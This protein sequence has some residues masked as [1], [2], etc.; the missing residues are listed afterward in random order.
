[1]TPKSP[2]GTIL[3]LHTSEDQSPPRLSE[4]LE[5]IVPILNQLESRLDQESKKS[6]RFEVELQ[7]SQKAYE[8]MVNE[9]EERFIS[10]KEEQRK[11][12]EEFKNKLYNY[13]TN[14]SKLSDQVVQLEDELKLV[15]SKKQSNEERFRKQIELIEGEYQTHITCFE[16]QEIK[17][18]EYEIKT[19]EHQKNE[20]KLYGHV[21]K[22]EDELQNSI[23][24][25]QIKEHQ[26]R[27]QILEME[28][29]LRDSES[30][31]KNLQNK[32]HSFLAREKEFDKVLQEKIQ[33]QI[34]IKELEN[35]IKE[36][37]NQ[38]KSELIKLEKTLKETLE[39]EH[40]QRL[41]SEKEKFKADCERNRAEF[42]YILNRESEKNTA[43]GKALKN[44]L[45]RHELEFERN[46][47]IERERATLEKQILKQEY[48]NHKLELEQKFILE[49]EKILL[50]NQKLID[51]QENSKIEFENFVS[52]EKEKND[53]LLEEID[54]LKSKLQ[55]AQ[56][57]TETFKK[58]LEESSA[59]ADV[60]AKELVKTQKNKP[61]E[62]HLEHLSPK[63]ILES[64]EDALL[65]HETALNRLS[66]NDIERRDIQSKI[67]ELLIQR[68]ELRAL[69]LLSSL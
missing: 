19:K 20:E 29:R 34:F 66:P 6:R 35:K 22:I 43:E 44:E 33:D 55:K 52:L 51:G 23:L 24:E 40:S 46:L 1:M 4:Q 41:I 62:L 26:L 64:I 2:S 63:K 28:M 59:E 49:R 65:K 56:I 15:L 68:T 67:A 42:E 3:S 50:E 38:H 57:E 5:K 37:L 31:I 39:T 30:E 36:N 21:K 54:S 61:L 32:T 53:N 18:K 47:S 13:Q 10:K 60:Q 69:A 16:H 9:I 45:N 14:E 58:Y 7:R 8:Q 25:Y 48:E 27:D 11:E 12:R 17:L